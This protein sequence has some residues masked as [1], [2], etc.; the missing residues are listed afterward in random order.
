MRTRLAVVVCLLTLAIGAAACGDNRDAEPDAGCVPVDD[1]NDCTADV[2]V[3]GQPVS[4]DRGAGETCTGGVCDGQGAC[5]ECVEDDDCDG[6]DVCDEASNACVPPTC[7]DGEQNGDETDID[8]GGSCAPSQ[9]CDDGEGCAEGPDCTS[10]V[11]GATDTCSAPACGDG[12]RQGAEACDDGNQTNGDGCDDGTGGTCRP[13]GC[14]N[15]T[16]AGTE[17]CDDGNAVNGDGCDNNCTT[18]A[19]G[20]GVITTGETCDDMDTMPGDGCSATCAIETGF[21]CTMVPSVCVATCGDGMVAATEACDDA[22]PAESGDGCS[23]TCTVEPGFGCTG[24]PSVCTSVCGDGIRAPTEGCDDADTMGSDG[25]NAM[26]FVEPGWV[27]VGTPSTCFPICGD[28]RVVPTEPCDDPAPAENGDGCSSSCRVE[29]GWS[30]AGSPSTCVPICGDGLRLGME[31]CDDAPPAENG[32]GCSATCT[33]ESGWTCT[34][35]SPS[36]CTSTCGDGIPV[37]TEACD[38]APPAES[39][40][41]CSATCTIET[42]FMCSGAPS[43]CAGICGDGMVVLGEPCDDAPPAESGDGCSATCTVEVGYNCQGSP[44]VCALTCGNNVLDSGETCDDGANVDGDG[45]SAACTIEQGWSCMGEPSVCTTTCGDGIIA[46]GVEACDD[47]PPAESGDGCSATCTIESGWVCS[48]AMQSTCNTV[49]GD[50]IT[51]GTETCDDACAIGMP[52]VCEPTDNGDGCSSTCQLEC[53]DGT[54]NNAIEQCDDGNR[55]GGDR[56]SSTC[57]VEITCGP[58][59]SPVVLTNRTPLSPPDNNL[60]GVQSPITVPGTARVEKAVVFVAGVT[61]QT[62]A[63]IDLF[64]IG[65]TGTQRELS[66]DN[67]GI[68]Y[69]QTYFDDAAATAVTAGT[70][71]YTGAFRPEQSLTTTIG[72]DFATTRAA[73]TWNLRIADDTAGDTGTLEAWTLALC[74]ADVAHCGD[75]MINGTDECDDG[76]TNNADAC[77]NTCNLTDGCGDGNIDAGEACDDDNLASGD[78]CSSTCQPDITCAQGE[79][80]VVVTNSTPA[81]IPDNTAGG[82][83]SPV[84]VTTVGAVTRIALLINS[85]THLNDADLDIFLVGPT[86]L[87]REVSTDNGSTGDHYRGTRIDDGAATAITSGSAPMT[88]RFRPEQTLSATPTLDFRS[89]NAAGTW[90]LNVADDLSSNTGTLDAWTLTMCVQPGAYCGDGVQNGTDE[91]DDAN[92]NDFDGC[93]SVCGLTEGCGDGNL[94]AGEECDDNNIVSGDGCSSSCVFDITCAAGET[95]VILR[96]TAAAPIPD[97]MAG[98]RSVVSQIDVPT[99]GAVRKVQALVNVTHTDLSDVDLFLSSPF[100]TERA[101]AEDRSGTAFAGTVFADTGLVA[102]NSGTSPYHGTYRPAQ[103]LSDLA[104]FAGQWPVGTWSLRATDDFA[105]DVGTLNSWAI[106]LCVDTTVTAPQCGNGWVE[107]GE[108]CDD[109]NT[110]VGDGCAACQVELGCAAGEQAVFVSSLGNGQAIDDNLPTG[111]PLKSVIV[112]SGGTVR[113]AVVVVASL[114]HAFVG[115]VELV[116]TSA[117]GTTIDISSDNGSTADHMTSTIFDDGAAT[118]FSAAGTVGPYRGRFRPDAPLTVVN[119]QSANGAWSLRASDDAGIDA[120]LFSG[121]ILGLC[122]SP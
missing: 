14:G 115:D 32:D 2:C 70:A 27:C 17:V 48:G 5:V 53:G 16:R 64:L 100:G 59:A 102:I 92:T 89:L 99:A 66:T 13:T 80:P 63:H 75:G 40:D 7:T 19:C 109:T 103:T 106:G 87:R 67:A 113:K 82:V 91:C 56:C 97:D 114:S 122:V 110:A 58:G 1:G 95:P 51:A 4:Q 8:C 31:A 117:T 84:D 98:D 94:D 55:I 11:C 30:C 3:D 41:G 88:G 20:N 90:Q 111:G 57:G 101:L 6:T 107:P 12:V 120:G 72:T 112:G 28:S 25:C 78:G 18:T 54:L 21:T 15:G 24:S 44:S 29:T 79:V 65:P 119:G 47:A 36:T 76:N 35:A 37:G 104:G 73:G 61:H 22:P 69:R 45:C 38:D 71:P 50:G 43:T 52:G 60:P 10:G 118:A 26:C 96:N 33:V 34:M 68:N 85:I 9:R 42:G 62:D 46:V 108:T 83:N 116:L 74:V 81:S 77:S 49:C 121:W 23:I 39:G 86:G 105:T 93:N